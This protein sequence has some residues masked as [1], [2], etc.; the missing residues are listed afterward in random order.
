MKKGQIIW[1]FY[2][3][4]GMMLSIPLIGADW[5]MWRYD[6][7]R[8]AS[9]EMEF[10]SD[11]ELLWTRELP[12][13]QRCWP[14]QYE[15][16]YTGGN[17]LEKGK[18]SFDVSYEPVIGKGL[19]FVPSMVSDHVTAYSTETGEKVWR[20]YTEGPVR[21]APVFWEDNLYFIS[22][23]GYLY[24]LE[25]ATGEKSWKFQGNYSS[26]R[27]LGNERLISMWPGRGGPVIQDGILYFASGAVPYE[28]VFIHA[29]DAHT[30]EVIWTNST[31]GSIWDLHQHGGAYSFGGPL[32][33]G[34]LAVTEDKLLVPGGRTPPA[35][36]D[37]ESGE[38]LYFRQATGIVGKGA[39]GYQVS[40]H[41][42][43]FFN[44]NMLYAL[45]DGAQYGP[46]TASVITDD[47][48][49]GLDNGTFQVF[50][51]SLE[52]EEIE[53]EDRLSRG[54]IREKY[55]LKE[56]R[57]T[58]LDE[59]KQLFIKMDG[60]LAITRENGNIALFE[61]TEEGEPGE[62]VW[63]HSIDGEVWNVLAG[64]EKLFVITENGKIYCFGEDRGS[65]PV[66]Y[67]EEII[68]DDLDMYSVEW[69]ENIVEET[70]ATAGYAY[71]YGADNKQLLQALVEQ[72]SLHLIVIEPD[73][74]RVDA[75][76]EYFDERGM[77]GQRIA[78]ICDEPLDFPFPP[79]LAELV[80]MTEGEY[81]TDHL[82]QGF[83]SLR[84]YGGTIYLQ[85][86]A[87]EVE[88]KFEQ[89]SLENG[90]FVR[91]E[92]YALVVREGPLPGAG[93]WTHQYS[94]ASN[95]TYSDDDLVRAPMGVLWFGGPSNKNTLPRHGNG[96]IPQV[97]GG[98]LFILGIDTLS[99]RCVY[100]GRELWVKDFPEI[101][102]PFTTL[103]HERRFRDGQEVYMP[104]HP[105]ANF[106]G[107]PYV[108]KEDGVYVIYEDKLYCLDPS[109][110]EVEVEF[111]IPPLEEVRNPEWGHVMVWEDLLIA[112]I[113]PQI[114][115]DGEIGN[116]ENWNATSSSIILV[117]D[118]YD[119][120]VHWA[121]KAEQVGFRHNAIVAGDGKLF[122]IDGISS[123]ARELLER[124]GVEVEEESHLLA[125]DIRTGRELWREEEDVFGTWL[126][127]Y[128]EYNTLLQGGRHGAR[129]VPPDE[130]RERLKA[131]C[132]QSGDE[133]WTYRE[134]YT[135]PL[136][137]HPDMIIPGNPGQRAI[138][139][140]TGEVMLQK[141]PLT[142]E[143]YR[144]SYHRYYGCGTMNAS[145]HMI[146]FRSGAAGFHDLKNLGGT[147]NF[148]GFRSGCTNN[149][150]AADGL[151]N[152]PEYT[153]TCTCSYQLQTSLGLVHKPEAEMWTLNRLES[154][155]KPI[156]TIGINFGAQGNRRENDVLW[157]E[158]P[159]IYGQGPDVPLELTSSSHEW[160]R[161]HSSWIENPEDGYEWVAS[162]GAKGIDSLE[163][164][165]LDEESEEEE[166]SYHVTM[167]FAEP[168]D[169]GIGER[170]FDVKVQGEKV[171]EGF[172]IY[173]ET[174]GARRLVKKEFADIPVQDI[175][176]IEFVNG[177]APSVISGIEIVCQ[178][179]K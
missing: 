174:G 162:Y 36:F 116:T 81:T 103:E 110:G 137:L 91:N 179:H 127:Y 79:Y 31:S 153:R 140:E 161:N 154:G 52:K 25:A 134:R 143:E 133:K 14:F 169:L 34:Y 86:P 130:P 29:V 165:L 30:G 157:L 95:T 56:V 90:R 138:H 6:T 75:L 126:G 13:P 147:G 12:E 48:F 166:K 132:G 47:V 171:L 22:D 177:N 45:E 148:G 96:P 172:D 160:F 152:A 163:V 51:T 64:D 10:T 88:A 167:Y 149:L 35:V 128:E 62:I 18:L 159:K 92:D 99:A 112:T 77:Y 176:K 1:V 28:G 120:G 85:D 38:L 24:C 144:W 57:E 69:A 16:Y 115:D 39:G 83:Q 114:F 100:T 27:V 40:V 111:R 129:G 17:P 125:F 158:Y 89:A 19:L 80:L 65:D 82:K 26:R 44:H 23:D 87:E 178:D 49:M 136:G 5:P 4:F 61:L 135:G 141:H 102:H 97:A 42:D 43:W 142:G 71:V 123:G 72:T 76:R 63:E 53:I 58:T 131:H 170:R 139:P 32:P 41:G 118:R 119:G 117:M 60:L 54:A 50:S 20:Y 67:Q 124:R 15:D 8:R 21:F 46:V 173:E 156:Q 37:R 78:L 93:Q 9:T 33:Q 168:E 122:T 84:P 155:Q 107:S 59:G 70:N 145:R 106:I 121:R 68:E 3:V 109:S 175:L 146:N 108:S 105:G 164:K 11:A 104:N 151:L 101:G 2:I 94:D 113:D 150:I 74:E 55:D 73:E 98:K 7:G 66:H